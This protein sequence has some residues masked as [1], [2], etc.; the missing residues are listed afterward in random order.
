M[1]TSLDYKF[2]QLLIATA[3]GDVFISNDLGQPRSENEVKFAND[4]KL[5][6]Q[7]HFKQELWGLAI[8]PN[9][10]RFVTCG[11]DQTVR[12]W[13]VSRKFEQVAIQTEFKSILRAV[14]WAPSGEFIIAADSKGMIYLL[15]AGKLDI[16]K[17]MQSHF[18]PNPKKRGDPWIEDLKISP[19]SK[20][21]A[22]GAHGG[23]FHMQILNCG[24]NKL[25]NKCVINTRISSALIHLDWCTDNSTIVI[26]SQAYELMW[27]DVHS[28]KMS[29][30]IKDYDQ[31][32]S[33]TCKV[34]F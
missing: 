14:D 33:W 25:E 12:L 30:P 31:Y 21:C 9:S 19:D 1:I 18:K 15:D 11:D 7:G 23:N 8:S 28:K 29:S 22:F 2:C 27:F 5:V 17:S 3:G 13:D 24:R 20:M 4:Y 32:Y 26:N 34:G 16:V 6:Q 10:N